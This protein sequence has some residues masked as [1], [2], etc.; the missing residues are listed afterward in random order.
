MNHSNF[1]TPF[2]IQM[3]VRLHNHMVSDRER[4]ERSEMLERETK[5]TQADIV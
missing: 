1:T 2:E 3:F 5:S 4:K